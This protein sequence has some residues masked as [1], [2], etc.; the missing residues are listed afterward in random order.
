[1][2][3]WLRLS[4]QI[5]SVLLF[6]AILWWA[7]PDVWR[8]LLD[9]SP[10]ALLLFLLVYGLAGVIS[11]TRFRLMTQSLTGKW[12]ASWR[13]F[14]YLNWTAR[15][16]GLVLPRSV[17]GV[18][19]KAVGLKAYGVSLKY[20]VWIVVVDNM[21]DVLLLAAMC[22]PSVLFFQGTLN[23]V[24][25][26]AGLGM[27]FVLL[28]A[29]IAWGT[30]T[31]RLWDILQRIPFLRSRLPQEVSGRLLPTTTQALQAWTWTAALNGV[32]ALAFFMMGRAVGLPLPLPLIVAAYP[33]VQLSL[34]AAV[35]P[36]GLGLFELGWIG[37]LVLGGV[38]QSD[39][40]AYSVAQRAYV[41]VA[42]LVWA[43]VSLLVSLTERWKRV[44]S[45]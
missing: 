38:A 3:K 15:A 35:T 22:L 42:V 20:G 8:Q 13:Q 26:F 29:V 37:L 19:G 17:S 34:V 30:R 4:L 6:V 36:G 12:C 23:A 39:A 28:A 10:Q 7:G 5:L 9:S 41:V 44:D 1:M 45:E 31:D 43:A 24:G 16:L 33:I 11:A 18:G 25:L 21:F 32:L 2:K 14:Y 40:V 27:V